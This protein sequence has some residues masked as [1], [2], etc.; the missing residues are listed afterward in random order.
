M[1][2]TYDELYDKKK[3][4]I[5]CNFD[6]EKTIITDRKYYDFVQM[7]YDYLDT[8]DLTKVTMDSFY[9]FV[10]ENYKDYEL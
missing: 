7:I 3:N 4:Y 9:A 10:N 1:H 6:R 2:L 5:I 8:A